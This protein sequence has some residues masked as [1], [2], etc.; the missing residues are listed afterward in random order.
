MEERYVFK[1]VNQLFDKEKIQAKIQQL[2]AKHKNVK[3][4]NTVT[5][6]IMG[7]GRERYKEKFNATTTKTGYSDPFHY[8]IKNQAKKNTVRILSKA[9]KPKIC[10][11]DYSLCAKDFSSQDMI[12][13]LSRFFFDTQDAST[14]SIMHA[15]SS[16]FKTIYPRMIDKIA[17]NYRDDPEDKDPGSPG[18]D[19][20]EERFHNFTKVLDSLEENRFSQLKAI[21]HEKVFSIRP[22]SKEVYDQHCERY[23][24]ELIDLRIQN[25]MEVTDFLWNNLPLHQNMVQNYYSMNT[26]RLQTYIQA[27]NQTV[28]DIYRLSISDYEKYYLIK[29]V[30]KLYFGQELFLSEIVEFFTILGI[31]TINLI[32]NTCRIKDSTTTTAP[33]DEP[34][35]TTSEIEARENIRHIQTRSSTGG[36]AKY[37]RTKKNKRVK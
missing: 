5:L 26:S 12:V 7:H 13:Q 27:F 25:E 23:H 17:A 10:A 19:G 34:T 31:D 9:G 8:V 37:A 33:H 29:V 30:Y 28:N 36:K 1:D 32:D 21:S 16:Y 22:E 14:F 2:H 4:G 15:L 3:E 35:P 24:F 20:Y 11:W 18:A 6:L